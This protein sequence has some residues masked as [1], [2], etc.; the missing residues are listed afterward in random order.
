M[1][2][3]SL[4]KIKL[5]TAV[6]LLCGMCNGCIFTGVGA[7]VGIL[8]I[9]IPV[10]PYFQNMQE[11][12]AFEARYKSAPGQKGA[13]ILDP[14]PAGRPHIAE[15]PPSEDEIMRAFLRVHPIQGN[16]PG[17]FEVQHNNVRIVTEKVQ[18][19]VDPPRVC[20]LMGPIQLHHSHWICKVYYTEIIRNGWPTPYTAKG[21]DKMEII[22]IDKD[23]YHRVGNVMS[24]DHY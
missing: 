12:R 9:P 6:L 24:G 11:D 10:S 13:I 5:L 3:T 1:L 14:I 2:K 8:S 20:P 21:E 18:D 19:I 4:S 23:H 7:N 17:L 22:K 16:V 15:D